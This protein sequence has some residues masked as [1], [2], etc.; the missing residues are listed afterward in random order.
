[1]KKLQISASTV[2]KSAALTMPMI[3]FL[4]S[5]KRSRTFGAQLGSSGRDPEPWLN[6]RV[7]KP[8]WVELS[9]G[10]HRPWSASD[11]MATFCRAKDERS[12]GG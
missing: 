12:V 6:W 11:C 2:N 10:D 8:L 1:M 4:K 7:P 3:F 5:D 9:A